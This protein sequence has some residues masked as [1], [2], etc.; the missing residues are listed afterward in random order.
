MMNALQ[1]TDWTDLELLDLM[2]EKDGK[3]WKEFHRRFDRLIYRCIHK[4]TSRF[5]S[6][7]CDDDVREIYAQ[8]LINITVRNMKKLR[9]YDP[10][11]ASKLSSWIGLLVTNTAWD[12][13]RKISRQP[14]V[15]D[16]DDAV[17]V[18]SYDAGPDD[19][20]LRKQRWNL[21]QE[22]L[23]GFS[24]RD[25]R[26]VQLYFVDG[27]TPEQIANNME[28]SVKTVYSKKHKIRCRLEK[29]L[30]AAA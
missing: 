25:Q 22:T 11:R 5:R 1:P 28:I 20:L 17:G 29:E 7:L 21:V 9:A 18:R 13:L 24:A 16:L 2:L 8:F 15:T 27:M 3:A 12:H 4:I 23:K 6:V 30:R 19:E 10:T 26:F 14:H